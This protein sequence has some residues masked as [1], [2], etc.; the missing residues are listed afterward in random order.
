ME[1]TEHVLTQARRIDEQVAELR[2][3]IRSVSDIPVTGSMRNQSVQ[4]ELLMHS[5]ASADEA[6]RT[7]HRIE[8]QV[9]VVEGRASDLKTEIEVLV[10]MVDDAIDKIGRLV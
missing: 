9:S 4:R 7:A 2:A 5:P 10:S 1:L 8:N 6:W 3:Q